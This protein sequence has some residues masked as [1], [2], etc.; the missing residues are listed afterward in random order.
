MG[1]WTTRPPAG[2]ARRMWVR[3]AGMAAL[4][5]GVSALTSALGSAATGNPVLSLLVGLACAAGVLALYAVVVRAWEARPVRE[6]ERAS[7]GSGLRD[8]VL[9][10]LGLFAV[11]LGL[12]A[13]CG[14]YRIEG[15]GSFGGALS[16]LGLMAGVAVV[17][18]VLFRGI[19]FRL[20]EE[21]TG[22]RGA[23]VIS[24]LL[25]G[26]LHLITPRATV[27]GALAIAVE[28]GLMLGAAYVLTRALWLPIG[29][30]LGWNAA[31]S[32][33]FGAPVSGNEGLPQG[34]LDG[35]ASG[36]AVLSGGEFGPEASLFAVLVCGAATVVLLRKAARGGRI[37]PRGGPVV[38]G[39]S[40]EAACTQ[41]G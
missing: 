41:G 16:V 28:A 6:L 24:A 32:A 35:A 21:A 38:P 19:V 18:E 37:R 15:W 27:W 7:A 12:I 14:G 36:P 33:L 4:F 31:E 34:L 40:T 5:G 10:G 20:V 29:L 39:D 26:G 17:E 23:L 25:F 30:H 8:G 22:T 9:G 13:L 11:T 3:L 1:S 2:A